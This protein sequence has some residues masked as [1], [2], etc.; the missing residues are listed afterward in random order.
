MGAYLDDK[1]NVNTRNDHFYAFCALV[2]FW[3]FIRAKGGT[4][5]GFGLRASGSKVRVEFRVNIKLNSQIMPLKFH[6][7]WKSRLLQANHHIEAQWRVC[8]IDQF[9]VIVICLLAS[10]LRKVY[11]LVLT[12]VILVLTSSC[13]IQS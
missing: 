3:R 6:L 1:Q 2:R 7:W 4:N 10:I 5:L 13:E 8:G 12:K 11:K 9:V